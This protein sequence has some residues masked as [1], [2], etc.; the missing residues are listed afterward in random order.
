MQTI[1]LF[2]IYL[3]FFNWL[4]TRISFFKNSGLNNWWLTGLFTLKI[5]AGLAYAFFYLQPS[6][7]A[8][9]DTWHYFDLSKGETDWL[10]KDPVAF[11]KDIFVSA[12][13]QRSGLFASTNSYWN[14]LKST[15]VIKLLAICNVFTFKNYFA[16]II[17]FNFFFFFG[18]VALYKLVKQLFSLNSLL[19]I[20]CIFLLPSFLFWCS[21]IHKDGFIFSGAALIAY[22]FNEQIYNRRINLRSVIISILCFIVV[23]ALRN[24]MAMLLLPALLIWLLCSFYPARSKIIIATV[25]GLGILLFF[26]SPFISTATNLPEYVIEKQD[27][28]KKLSG[29][30]AIYVPSLESSFTSFVKFL[31][32]AI[33]IAFFRP[34]VTEVNNKSYIP[35][36]AEVIC[37][38]LFAALFL[39][40]RKK[41]NKTPEQKAF[42]FFCICFAIS[43]LLLAGYT[44]T[45]S[46]AIVR[47]RAVVLPFLFVPV[48][49]GLQLNKRIKHITA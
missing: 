48:V 20:A 1:L 31:P 26:V 43:F 47:Y 19:L 27:E 23:F 42:L 45:F 34:H 5:I 10:L 29:T 8:T 2:I 7:Y 13:H 17:F 3:F 30:S 24:F 22:Y 25:Y 4:I 35:A 46:G 14:D 39:F 36:A 9:S 37:L 16:D 21:G 28:F 18:P 32:T 41:S 44:I 49:A 40:I 12:Y 38:W 33:D 11:F 15:V 6:Y